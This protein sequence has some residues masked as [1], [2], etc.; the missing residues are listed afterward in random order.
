M[1]RAAWLILALMLVLMG[2]GCGSSSGGPATG[3][4]AGK[5]RVVTTT[6]I[7]ADLVRQLGGDQV[8]VTALMGPGVDPHLYKASPGDIQKLEKADLIVSNGLHLEGKM[9][10]VLEQLAKRKRVHAF[11][12]GI[13]A[14]RLIEADGA[15]DPHV[16]FDPLLLAEGVP[17]LAEQLGSE[18]KPGPVLEDLKKLHDEV[19]ATLAAVPKNRRILVT[20]HDAFRYFGRAYE[21]EVLGVQGISTE[22]EAGLREINQLVDTLV[23]KKI[24]AVF[25]ESSVSP[26]GVQALIE[27]ARQRWSQVQEGGSL[28]S[29]A[30]G[31]AASGADTYRGMVL[32]NA[33]TI[34]EALK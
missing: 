17:E 1:K 34:A 6:G 20:A 16:W 23:S 3:Q 24:P 32:A 15:E 28:Y 21:F 29:D 4:Q 9:A 11:S 12:D 19:E 13:P 8:E 2:L 25:I 7:L 14:D 26:R 31:D 27:G 33:K 5:L 10:A 18:V 30:L 22:S